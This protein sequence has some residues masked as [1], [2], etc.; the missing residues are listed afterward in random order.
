MNNGHI[1]SQ[2]NLFGQPRVKWLFSSRL[3]K[4]AIASHYSHVIMNAMASQI[5]GVSIVCSTVYSGAD[6]R[7]HQSSA[8]LAL[9]RGIQRWLADSPHKRPAKQKNVSIWWRHHGIADICG[10]K[11]LSW[12]FIET[13]GPA[14]GKGDHE[15]AL[16]ATGWHP[17]SYYSSRYTVHATRY[18]CACFAGICFMV[19]I[20]WVLSG[21]MWFMYP[22]Y[23][24]LCAPY[25]YFGCTIQVGWPIFHR[26]AMTRNVP[27]NF[28]LDLKR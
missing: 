16:V 15:R 17:W 25:A 23:I 7:K 27:I 6:Q 5:N 11:S 20:L 8:P 3:T 10:A 28:K 14:Y 1:I 9:V 22:Y 13:P 26:D 19:V 12:C 21:S 24:G 4:H 18:V 2:A